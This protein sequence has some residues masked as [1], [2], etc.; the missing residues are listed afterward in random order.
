MTG[1]AGFKGNEGFQVS[2]VILSWLL[3]LIRLGYL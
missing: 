2:E 3:Q 1:S